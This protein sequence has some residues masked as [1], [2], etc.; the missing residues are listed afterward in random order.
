[1]VHSKRN[2]DSISELNENVDLSESFTWSLL[3]KRI[4]E[5]LNT[6]ETA[7]SSGLSS[8]SKSPALEKKLSDP[9]HF[10]TPKITSFDVSTK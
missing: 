10:T 3:E 9:F 7:L 1:M 5:D 8:G 2:K 6:L 4:G